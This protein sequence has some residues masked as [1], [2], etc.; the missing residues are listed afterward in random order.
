MS[1]RD[2][3][4]QVTEMINAV[5]EEV[6]KSGVEL[7]LYLTRLDVHRSARPLQITETLRE[8]SKRY[9]VDALILLEAYISALEAGSKE[10]VSDDAVTTPA[11]NTDNPPYWSHERLVKRQQRRQDRASKKITNYL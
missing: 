2:G 8:I 7:E 6:M 1:K 4:I 3:H 5:N 9:P 11:W 10:L